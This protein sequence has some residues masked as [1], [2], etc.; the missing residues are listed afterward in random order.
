MKLRSKAWKRAL[1][2]ALLAPVAAHW[3][4]MRQRCAAS[5]SALYGTAVALAHCALG[6]AP[7]D[8]AQA[9]D[10]LLAGRLRTQ[11]PAATPLAACADQASRL[12]AAAGAHA[13][14]LYHRSPDVT[15]ALQALTLDLE[16]APW[17]A[18]AA[19]LAVATAREALA[20]D[21]DRAMQDACALARAERSFSAD[22]LGLCPRGGTFR[23]KLAPVPLAIVD[24][25]GELEALTWTQHGLELGLTLTLTG[26][27]APRMEVRGDPVRWDWRQLSTPGAAAE[28]AA[29]AEPDPSAPVTEL[30][31][32]AA[33]APPTAPPLHLRAEGA[34]GL[35]YLTGGWLLLHRRPLGSER[36]W[37]AARVV[38]ERDATGAVG[39]PQL[40]ATHAGWLVTWRRQGAA[41]G[42]VRLEGTLQRFP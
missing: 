15:A 39:Q 3:L 8:R 17:A 38:A 27:S 4:W 5:A 41:R 34:E 19:L 14:L 10:T 1:P 20:R 30:T 31:V 7:P 35:L 13:A 32:A 36:G 42:R 2:L 9:M 40:V 28:P 33:E 24:V 12:A 29:S 26:G 25:P 16:R 22:E 18:P 23:G 37:G 6:E 21:L 11:P